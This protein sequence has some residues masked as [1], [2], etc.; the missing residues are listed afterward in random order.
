[1]TIKEII[2]EFRKKDFS[3][4]IIGKKLNL[5]RQ[6]VW[7]IHNDI[8]INKMVKPEDL[9]KNV[10]RKREYLGIFIDKIEYGSG[11]RNL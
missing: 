1:M 5:S 3:Y 2:K 9:K 6:R 10:K 8:Y 7:Q 4:E 11:G